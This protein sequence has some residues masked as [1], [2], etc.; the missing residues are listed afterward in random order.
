MRRRLAYVM[1]LTTFTDFSLRVLMYLAA[2]PQ[3]RA[4]IAEIADVFGISE[5][6]LTKVVHGLGRGGWL[7]NVRGQG[8][9][10]ELAM[11]PQHIV[12]GEVVRYTE[13]ADVPAACFADDGAPCVIAGVCRLRGVLGEAF[14]AFHA[15]LDSTTLADLARNPH[16]LSR[17]LF[18]DR[19]KPPRRARRST[20]ASQT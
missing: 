6:H 14:R 1:R 17:V 3:R 9:G 7:A 4:T 15:V 2:E 20:V 11:S 10:L 13:G 19:A 16:A 5:H 12:L 18:F 8:G